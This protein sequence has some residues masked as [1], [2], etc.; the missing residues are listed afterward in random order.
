MNIATA[1]SFADHAGELPPEVL[2]LTIRGLC[3][4]LESLTAV[5]DYLEGEDK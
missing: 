2:A 5:I 4:Q 1:R 3:D